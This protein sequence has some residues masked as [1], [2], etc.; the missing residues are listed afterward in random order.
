MRKQKSFPFWFVLSCVLFYFSCRKLDSEIPAPERPVSIDRFFNLPASADPRL[1]TIAQSIRAQ[2]NKH[3]FLKDFTKRAG[4]P[5]W[6][7][8]KIILPRNLSNG[9]TTN[10]DSSALVYI[11]F[12]IDS[13]ITVNAVLAVNM[14]SVDTTW[15]ILYARNYQAFG[16]DTTSS[17][18]WN[19]RDVFQFFALF[20]HDIFGHTKFL[21]KDERLF[22]ST[23]DSSIITLK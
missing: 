17:N 10:G 20:D 6:D 4:W 18:N 16:F 5:V 22:N 8:S 7:K 9:R 13:A 11:P 3:P 21:L 23:R 19:A 12:V 2:E 14:E 15:R 1:K